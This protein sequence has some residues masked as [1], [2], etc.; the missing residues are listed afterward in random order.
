MLKLCHSVNLKQCQVNKNNLPHTELLAH[1]APMS[2]HTG[3]S[4]GS[5]AQAPRPEQPAFSAPAVPLPTPHP[6]AGLPLLLGV[7]GPVTCSRALVAKEAET[8][9]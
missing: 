9:R 4:V 7:L 2:G 6:P 8:E 3:S 1:K 5:L